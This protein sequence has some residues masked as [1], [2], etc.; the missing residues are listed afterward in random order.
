MR[1]RTA[2]ERGGE[3]GRLREGVGR[4]GG[5]GDGRRGREERRRR[6]VGKEI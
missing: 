5:G 3:E 6:E 1:R 2:G 4:A